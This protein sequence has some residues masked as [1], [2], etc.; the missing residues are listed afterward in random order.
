MSLTRQGEVICP[1]LQDY[2]DLLYE[3]EERYQSMLKKPDLTGTIGW[4]K[5]RISARLETALMKAS[6]SRCDDL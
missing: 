1:L 2:I 5:G 6:K 3:T 4:A